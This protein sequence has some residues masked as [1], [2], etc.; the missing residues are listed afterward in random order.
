MP[1]TSWVVNGESRVGGPQRIAWR[2]CPGL[3]ERNATSSAVSVYER[4]GRLEVGRIAEKV[5]LLSI[6][7]IGINLVGSAEVSRKVID[8]PGRGALEGYDG[9]QRPALEE[10]AH[11]VLAGEVIRRRKCEAMSYIEL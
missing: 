5:P 8:A 11:A 1:R 2:R 10:L 9:I 7:G 3:E 4:L 6:R